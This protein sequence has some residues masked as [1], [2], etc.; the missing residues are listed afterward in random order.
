MRLFTMSLQWR[1]NERDGVS[2]HRCLHCFK[3]WRHRWFETPSRLN[4]CFW[5][6]SKKT[7][8]LRVTDLCAGIWPL[9]VE[10]PAQKASNAENVSIWWRHHVHQARPGQS[11]EKANIRSGSCLNQTM[12]YRRHCPSPVTLR[13]MDKLSCS[14][15]QQNKLNV[16][17]GTVMLIYPCGLSHAYTKGV[18][19]Y[20]AWRQWIF[21]D[22][23]KR[24][25]SLKNT[26]N[27]I[28]SIHVGRINN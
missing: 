21:R 9:T 19:H 25:I 17:N 7:S 28:F 22:E 2:N 27:S 5:R 16:V 12:G 20:T 26:I 6:R 8:K 10:F 4:C 13:N 11:E 14:E 3:Q 18:F 23:Y 24:Q 1:H 15:P